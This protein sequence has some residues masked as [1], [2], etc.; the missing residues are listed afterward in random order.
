MM[1]DLALPV[2][3]PTIGIIALATVYLVSK[4]PDRRRRAWQ[5][6]KLLLRR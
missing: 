3:V 1:Y 6:L 2:A 4:D 5:L